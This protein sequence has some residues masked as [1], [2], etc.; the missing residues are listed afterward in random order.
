M[1]NNPVLN[2]VSHRNSLPVQSLQAEP[3]MADTELWH[4]SII[5]AD[6]DAGT[7]LSSH[8]AAFR[9]TRMHAVYKDTGSYF[10]SRKMHSPQLLFIDL[11]LV[12]E[13]IARQIKLSS[14]KIIII[15]FGDENKIKLA[16]LNA[17]VFNYLRSPFVFGDVFTVI[18]QVN[19]YYSNFFAASTQQKNFVLIKSE[20]KLI[21]VKLA[22]ILFIAGMKD[23]IKIWL[24]EKS[25]PLTTLQ[26]LKEFERKLPQHDFIRVHK[27][28]IVSL[29]H[30]DCIARN[31]ITIGSYSIPVGDAF[32]DGLNGFIAAHS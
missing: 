11:D 28:Y 14:E 21:K 29:Q 1:R 31:E 26:N 30:I 5:C 22:D 23:Y 2:G 10:L 27:S 32:R 13:E 16:G 12:N 9:Q 3:Y 7:S 24:K 25:A 19:L 6:A 17:W 20:Y 15:G 18:S 8:I 4:V